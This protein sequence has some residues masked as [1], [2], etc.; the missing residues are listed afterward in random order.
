MV[1]GTITIHVL[2]LVL[3][4]YFNVH[5][6]CIYSITIRVYT[7][8]LLWLVCIITYSIMAGV[9]YH[10]HD[11]VKCTG[12]CLVCTITYSVMFSVQSLTAVCLVYAFTHN[13]MVSVHSLIIMVRM[14]YNTIS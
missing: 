12:L 7:I 14:H 13:I 1:H 8:T 5:Y 10:L 11:Y 6:Y 2:W 4:H 9:Y 3:S